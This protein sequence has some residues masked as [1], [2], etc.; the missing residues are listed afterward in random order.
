[1][2]CLQLLLEDICDRANMFGYKMYSICQ[3]K[4]TSSAKGGCGEVDKHAENIPVI[5]I[6]LILIILIILTILQT[7]Q[8]N[9]ANHATAPG[10]QEYE[11]CEEQS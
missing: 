2:T 3:A 9:R 7:S 11:Y 5:P 4:H 6:I 10:I 8:T 1:M